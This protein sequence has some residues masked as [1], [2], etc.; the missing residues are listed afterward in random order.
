MKDYGSGFQAPLRGKD[1][2]V[3]GPLVFEPRWM[4]VKGAKTFRRN[5]PAIHAEGEKR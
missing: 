4:L 3:P 5:T 1:F 2:V